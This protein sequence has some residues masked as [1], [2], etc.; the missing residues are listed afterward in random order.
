M[1]PS[2]AANRE[3]QTDP[4]DQV[5]PVVRISAWF[6]FLLLSTA[7]VAA[8]HASSEVNS[9]I[10]DQRVTIES[11]GWRL[12]G[13][14]RRGGRTDVRSPA[15]LL[16]NQAAGNR[17]AYETM[18]RELESLGIASLRLDLRGH[19][20]SINLGRFDPSNGATA[21]L[22]EGTD[23]DVARAVEW[24][25]RTDVVDAGRIGIIG[26]SYSGEAAVQASRHG[27]PPQAIA[28]LSPGSLSP[29]SMVWLDSADIPWRIVAGRA[30]RS[31]AVRGVM[32]DVVRNHATATVTLVATSMAH[33]TNMLESRP[34]LVTD[35]AV[36]IRAILFRR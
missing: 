23:R 7:C 36:W 30:E 16:L 27:A 21:S 18:A 9:A 28:L 3:V 26:A 35:L 2:T 15:V 29:E 11:D 4:Q 1:R 14:F 10:I 19:G 20:E 12:S 8:R 34:E 31:A 13:D 33:G 17:R 5:A 6:S 32:D 22:L 25:R 24:L